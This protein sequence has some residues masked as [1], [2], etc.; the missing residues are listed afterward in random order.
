MAS[1][2]RQQITAVIYDKRGRVLSVGQNSYIKTHPL[3]AAHAKKVGEDHK[4]FLHA[5]IAAIIRCRDIGRAHR[6]LVTRFGQ[7]G[8]PLLAKPCAVCRSAIAV[9][10]IQQVDHT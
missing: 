4:I 6:M 8:Q 3:Q 2:Q 9:A 1:S 7:Q 5:E 10:G